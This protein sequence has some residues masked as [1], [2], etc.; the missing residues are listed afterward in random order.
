MY[1]IL[2]GQVEYVVIALQRKA[3]KISWILDENGR[4]S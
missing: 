4:R 2:F 1:I 3:R